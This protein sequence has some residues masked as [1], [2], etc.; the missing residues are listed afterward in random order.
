[1]ENNFIQMAASAGHAVQTTRL[2][3]FLSTLP[4]VCSCISQMSLKAKV[5][6]VQYVVCWLAR[7]KSQLNVIDLILI[8]IKK[9]I[10]KK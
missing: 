2:V 5:A 6:V 10:I 4:L 9:K 1:M 7:H 3:Q 8:V